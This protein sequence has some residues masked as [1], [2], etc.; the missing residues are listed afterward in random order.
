M[1]ENDQTMG[2]FVSL[3]KGGANII[4]L[5]KKTRKETFAFF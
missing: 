5:Q 4:V 2:G 3:P 1:T